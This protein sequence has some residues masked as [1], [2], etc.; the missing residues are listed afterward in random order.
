[1]F[2]LLRDVSKKEISELKDF[3]EYSYISVQDLNKDS[4]YLYISGQVP[5][6]SSVFS[7]EQSEKDKKYIDLYLIYCESN[8]HVFNIVLDFVK[9]KCNTEHIFL[10]NGEFVCSPEE[11]QSPFRQVENELCFN[12]NEQGEEKKTTYRIS[13]IPRCS[14]ATNEDRSFLKNKFCL[15]NIPIL[16]NLSDIK[17]T[18]MDNDEFNRFFRENYYTE[19]GWICWEEEYSHC[20]FFG[21]TYTCP[22][23]ICNFKYSAKYI[24]GY[25][26]QSGKKIAIAIA[27]LAWDTGLTDCFEKAICISYVEVNSFCR[28]MGIFNML[29]E[30]IAEK[31]DELDFNIV[32]CTYESRIGQI[33]HTSEHIAKALHNKVVLNQSELYNP[34]NRKYLKGFKEV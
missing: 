1:M 10:Y 26:E 32:V 7:F 17:R 34:E 33:V 27:K 29:C 22:D 2:K 3:F 9:E 12:Q 4:V 11:Y 21:L 13:N 5:K 19:N 24:V 16:N 14:A 23:L 6:I 18:F 20:D 28:K 15:E 25:I 8:S 31:V 30:K